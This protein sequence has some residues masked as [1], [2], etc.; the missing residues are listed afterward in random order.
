MKLK[1]D[2]DIHSFINQLYSHFSTS[3]KR[4]AKLKTFYDESHDFMK[5]LNYIPIRWLSLYPAIDRLQRYK[6]QIKAYFL[7]ENLENIL[8]TLLYNFVYLIEHPNRISKLELY[9]LW[10]HNYMLLFHETILILESK[11]TNA[12]HLYGI[13]NNLK[14]R[15]ENR[16]KAKFY[17]SE[18]KKEL[19]FFSEKDKL[20][21][22]EAANLAY[23]RAIDY[24][25][26]WFDYE[27][28]I[29]KKLSIFDLTNQKI[30]YES[31]LDVSEELGIEINADKL[32]E[33]CH[34]L[35]QILSK[36]TIDKELT[37]DQAWC[38]ILKNINSPNI[39]KIIEVV[40]VI[41]IGNDFVE[42][43][44]SIMKNL[45]WD[46]RNR[47]SVEQVKA[48]ICTKVNFSMSCESFYEYVKTN[49]PLIK[50]AKSALKYDAP[51]NT[52]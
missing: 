3:S 50:A 21:F 24:L 7:D 46:E 8:P 6:D 14:S 37:N 42:R 16:M 18:V 11:S 27:N 28:S 10:S 49:V 25:S 41:P 20:E 5:I 45:W 22:Y 43:L 1:P 48:E 31:L 32:F 35:N 33:E 52:L 51:I 26:K 30:E 44:F 47:L 19:A 13:M 34:D 39:F 36:I 15:I 17:G 9:L 4:V 23:Q 38:K 12:T 29:F 40:L 2:V